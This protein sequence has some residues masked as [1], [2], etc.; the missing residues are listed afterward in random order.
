[1]LTFEIHLADGT[2][3]VEKADDYTV[4]VEGALRF[5]GTDA[6][7]EPGSWVHVVTKDHRLAPT[8]PHPKLEG[9]IGGISNLV[10]LRWGGSLSRDFEEV[11]RDPS[12]NDFRLFYRTT[13]ESAGVDPD[14][15]EPE[16]RKLKSE[17][18]DI[19]RRHRIPT[20]S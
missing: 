20:R 7:F 13:L 15:S 17:L 18:R 3:V 2:V 8:W 12:M 5:D 16:H 10:I 14:G 9:L 1:M 19:I 4:D 11:I 6:V